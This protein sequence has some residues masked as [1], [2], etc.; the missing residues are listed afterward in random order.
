MA[1]ER[2]RELGRDALQRERRGQSRGKVLDRPLLQPAVL[3][4]RG[5]FLE[6]A[7]ALAHRRAGA[8]GE[9]AQ[10]LAL[11][12]ERVQ[13][14]AARIVRRI[15]GG[16]LAPRQSARQHLRDPQDAPAAIARSVEEKIRARRVLRLQHR[17][18]RAARGGREQHVSVRERPRLAL[19]DEH[20]ARTGARE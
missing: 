17:R 1:G 19:Q 5:C 6:L 4:D 7:H 10:L 9:R 16:A 8:I 14:I 12:G 15:L 13:Q 2:A 11:G 3:D 20:A 18:D